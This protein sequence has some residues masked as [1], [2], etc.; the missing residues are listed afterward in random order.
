MFDIN[1]TVILDKTNILHVYGSG[2]EEFQELR[3]H[4]DYAKKTRARRSQF[5]KFVFCKEGCAV[6]PTARYFDLELSY[7]FCENVTELRL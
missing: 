6:L 3:D 4:F 1:Q 2:N 7:G 5:L